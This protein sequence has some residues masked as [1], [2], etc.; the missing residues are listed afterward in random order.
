MKESLSAERELFWQE[1]KTLQNTEGFPCLTEKQQRTIILSLYLQDRSERLA[2][3][4][5]SQSYLN[6]SICHESVRSLETGFYKDPNPLEG[7]FT[8]FFD[9]EYVPIRNKNE[10]IKLLVAFGFPSVIHIQRRLTNTSMEK[11]FHSC[12]ALGHNQDSEIVIWEKEGLMCPFRL[13]DLDAQFKEYGH[14]KYWGIRKLRN[15][16]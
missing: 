14:D 4:F 10:A 16:P 2:E 15:S 1:V 8:S 6:E 11:P 9:A 3:N 13:T 7:F 12:L 5:N